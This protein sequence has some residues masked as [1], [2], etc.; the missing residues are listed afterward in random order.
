M[1]RQHLEEK[2]G[3]EDKIYVRDYFSHQKFLQSKKS[4]NPNRSFE[5]ARPTGAFSTLSQKISLKHPKGG[6]SGKAWDR[7]TQICLTNPSTL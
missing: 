3:Y 2:K 4:S 7:Q 1:I 6:C 5:F